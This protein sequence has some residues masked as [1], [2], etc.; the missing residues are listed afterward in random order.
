VISPSQP[1]SSSGSAGSSSRYHR[2]TSAVSSKA[3]STGPPTI[4]PFSPIGWARNVK[5]VT[6]PKL[7][8]PPRNAQNRSGWV[9]SS[10]VTKV[11]SARTTSAESRL[12]MVRPNRRVR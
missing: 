11:P 8:P 6:T 10:A 4:T 2:I 7:P 3:Y 12:S 1:L 5:E 9:V